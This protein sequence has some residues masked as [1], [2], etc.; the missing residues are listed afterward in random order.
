MVRVDAL[1]SVEVPILGP[2]ASLSDA[3]HVLGRSVAGH[4]VVVRAGRVVGLVSEV[5]LAAALPSPATTLTRPEV[6]A[7]LATVA[8]E[9]VMRRGVACV[10]PQTPLVE[11]LRLMRDRRV[12]AL[13]VVEDGR[14]VG[15]LAGRDVLAAVPWLLDPPAAAVGTAA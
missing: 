7:R 14:L 3:A 9:T 11:A 12:G 5:D 2:K 10:R 1:M 4:V 8:V 6:D 15:L 13:P